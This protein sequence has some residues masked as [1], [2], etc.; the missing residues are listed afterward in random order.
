MSESKKKPKLNH[1]RIIMT[2]AMESDVELLFA[3][4]VGEMMNK[5][6]KGAI[7]KDFI[8]AYFDTREKGRDGLM[9]LFHSWVRLQKERV[10]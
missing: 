6:V 7:Q 8:Q 9:K 3:H 2:E 5:K 4:I 1:V 10:K